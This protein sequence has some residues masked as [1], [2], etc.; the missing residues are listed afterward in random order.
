MKRILLPALFLLFLL[1]AAH[2]QYMSFFGDSTWE[3]HVTYITNPPE[4][5]LIYPPEEP[6]ALGVYCK[7]YIYRFRKN[8]QTWWGG[9]IADEHSEQSP[10]SNI[11]SE[12]TSTG[13][14]YGASGYLICDLSLSVGDTFVYSE[15]L[16]PHYFVEP[17]G[18]RNMIVDSVKYLSG[19]KTIFLSLLDH[20]DDYFFGSESPL[21]GFDFSIRFIEGIGATYGLYPGNSDLIGFPVNLHIQPLMAIMLCMYKDDSLVYM[22]DEDLGCE[23]TCVGL[24]EYIHT[25]MNLYPNPASSY[26]VLDMGTGEEMDG[27]VIITDVMGRVCLQQHVAGASNLISVAD[28]PKGMYLDRK[29]VV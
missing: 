10:G 19:R 26:I 18:D 12:N 15:G 5:Y 8:H 16:E 17:A 4:D 14:L 11:L 29:S 7:T 27:D 28:F 6:S 22:A 13:R 2:G 20:H 1:P 21:Q 3:Y 23:Q 25:Y 24:E 9:Y